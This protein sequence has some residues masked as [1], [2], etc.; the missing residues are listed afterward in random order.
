MVRLWWSSTKKPCQP[1]S[2]HDS[3][4]VKAFYTNTKLHFDPAAKM[5]EMGG[6]LA[7]ASKMLSNTFITL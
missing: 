6:S 4:T 1:S 2:P 7:A 3:D 5:T